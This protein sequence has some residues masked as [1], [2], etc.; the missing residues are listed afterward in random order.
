[1]KD[2]SIR[3]PTRGKLRSTKKMIDEKF[4]SPRSKNFDTIV[5]RERDEM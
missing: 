2:I 3:G 5:N 1:M 4:S